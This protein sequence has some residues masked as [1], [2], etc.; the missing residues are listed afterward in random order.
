MTERLRYS[1]AD[2]LVLAQRS[3]RRIKRQ[4]YDLVRVVAEIHG[5]QI[6]ETAHKKPRANQQDQR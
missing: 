4:R 3:L 1:I 5:L 2:M 6:P